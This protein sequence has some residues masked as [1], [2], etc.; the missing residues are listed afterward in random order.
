MDIGI[1]NIKDIQVGKHLQIDATFTL[2]F[3]TNIHNDREIKIINIEAE[4]FLVTE[5]L[6]Q[7]LLEI[8]MSSEDIVKVY[9]SYIMQA[10][11]KNN[12]VI[13]WEEHIEE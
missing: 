2:T 11:E 4:L 7:D 10:Y 1:L 9:G 13:N 5:E 8:K 6:K 3:G 12:S